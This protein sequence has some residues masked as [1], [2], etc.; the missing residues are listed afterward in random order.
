LFGSFLRFQKEFALSKRICKNTEQLKEVLNEVMIRNKRDEINVY[1]PPRDVALLPV[2]LNN[3][4]KQLYEGV[5]S[6]I[7]DEYWNR[8]RNRSILLPLLT[9]QKEVCSS[10]AALLASL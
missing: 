8:L 2:K 4:E 7:R 5:T 6:L 1:F 3:E 10:P 9:L